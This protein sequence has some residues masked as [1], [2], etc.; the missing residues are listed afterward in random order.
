MVYLYKCLHFTFTEHELVKFLS[1]EST[2]TKTSW[3]D[4]CKRLFCKTIKTKPGVLWGSG[5]CTLGTKYVKITYYQLHITA[6]KG[7]HQRL[8]YKAKTPE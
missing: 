3:I 4:T 1:S 7:A 2:E 8:N 5:K 6:E